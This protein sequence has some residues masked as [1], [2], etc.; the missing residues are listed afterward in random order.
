[1]EWEDYWSS[2]FN[3]KMRKET[4]RI[5]AQVLEQMKMVTAFETEPQ[6]WLSAIEQSYFCYAKSILTRLNDTEVRNYLDLSD[7]QGINVLQRAILAQDFEYVKYFLSI[8][9]LPFAKSLDGKVRN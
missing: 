8:G 5:D 9:A 3:V 7:E 2:K 4:S 1:M 6:K